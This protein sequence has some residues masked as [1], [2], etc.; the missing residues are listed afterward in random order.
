MILRDGIVGLYR[1]QLKNADGGRA[2]TK[3]I[4]Q[5]KARYG[6]LSII[7]SQFGMVANAS[8]RIRILKPTNM[9]NDDI[10]LC[11]I[12]YNK[13]WHRVLSVWIG[14]DPDGSGRNV[15]DITLTRDFGDMQ[16]SSWEEIPEPKENI[17]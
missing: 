2:R 8:E 4:L 10:G 14:P 9:S 7:V 17:E 6:V 1:L 5:H 13:K 3:P 11:L 16:I 12:W 15:C